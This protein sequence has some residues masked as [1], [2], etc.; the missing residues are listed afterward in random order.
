VKDR[1]SHLSKQYCWYAG[2]KAFAAFAVFALNN[3]FGP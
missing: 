2:E 1:N 3:Y